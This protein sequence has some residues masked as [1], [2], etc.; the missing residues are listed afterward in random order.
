M[1]FYYAFIVIF[2]AVSLLAMVIFFRHASWYK[3]V[4]IHF[5]GNLRTVFSDCY[6]PS[7]SGQDDIISIAGIPPATVA[8]EFTR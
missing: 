4:V 3:S 7:C 8:I 5:H 2:M 6:R 1:K